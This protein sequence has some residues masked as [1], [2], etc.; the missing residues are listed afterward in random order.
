M[1][2]WSDLQLHILLNI[3]RLLLCLVHGVQST[4]DR[5]LWRLLCLAGSLDVALPSVG[6]FLPPCSF[7]HTQFLL[8][9]RMHRSS[10]WGRC[11]W[12]LPSCLKRRRPWCSQSV[13]TAHLPGEKNC[14]SAEG[15][16]GSSSGCMGQCSPVFW[17]CFI[18]MRTGWVTAPTTHHPVW[19]GLYA[20]SYWARD[21]AS[22]LTAFASD[23][24]SA[25]LL[26]HHK[27]AAGQGQ[28]CPILRFMF[29]LFVTLCVS[30]WREST[31]TFVLI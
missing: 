16:G 29:L 10:T 1:C 7:L 24:I 11:R 4:S 8:E 6:R 12:Q 22:A 5:N 13:K 14:N 18:R 15:V 26:T 27:G 21:I 25:L 28:V 23:P 19:N 9:P 17:E 30:T 31:G 2:N 3:H 20:G